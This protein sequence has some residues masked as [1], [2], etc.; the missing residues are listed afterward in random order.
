MPLSL[1]RKT[2]TEWHPDVTPEQFDR[3]LETETNR[4]WPEL[5]LVTEDVPEPELALGSLFEYSD[6]EYG[7]YRHHRKD[8]PYAIRSEEEILKGDREH[9]RYDIPEA[10]ALYI[11]CIRNWSLTMNGPAMCFST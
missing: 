10:Q 9:V 8:L 11:M 7:G 5:V 2:I 3:V 4:K 6:W 1:A